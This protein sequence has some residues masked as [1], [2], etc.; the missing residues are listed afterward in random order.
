MANYIHIPKSLQDDLW[1]GR[2]TSKMF[3]V[4]EWLLARAN[5]KTGEVRMVSAKRILHEQW[6]DDE[7]KLPDD[8]TIQRIIQRLH[9]CHYIVSHYKPGSKLSYKVTINNYQTAKRDKN[10]VVMRDDE[11]SVIEA[12]LNQIDTLDWRELLN[13]DV[14]DVSEKCRGNVGEMSIIH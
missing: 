7:D 9:N 2:I 3:H 14:A 5:F 1:E 8:R 13:P 10:G 11:L 12:V 6:N 4:M